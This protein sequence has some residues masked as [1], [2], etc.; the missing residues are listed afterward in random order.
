[1]VL[2]FRSQAS[3]GVIQAL[4]ERVLPAYEA[5]LNDQ[6]CSPGLFHRS[7]ATAR[8]MIAWLTINESEVAT[9][10]IRG[11]YRFLRHDCHCPADV[12]NQSAAPSPSHA[13][14]FLGYLLETGQAAV[15]ASIVAGGGLVEAFA[16]TLVAQ[17]YRERTVREVRSCCRHLVV[18]LYRSELALGAIEDRV[19]Q[20]FLDHRCD[21]EHPGF[22]GRS[23][24]FAGSRRTQAE[25]AK[26]ASF[27][28]DRDVVADWRD[29]LPKASGGAHT[30]AFLRWLRQHR[31]VRDTTLKAYRQSLQALL[32]LLGDAPGA[33]DAASVRAVILGRAQSGSRNTA[34]GS[35]LRSYLRFLAAQGLCRPGLVAAV[36][37]I[38]RRT[39][40]QLPRYV[41]QEDIEAL[42]ASCDT[43]TSIGLRD[44]AVLLLLARLALRPGEV[45][46]LRLDDIDWEQALVAVSGKSRRS[47]ALPLP[48][49]TGDTLKDYILRARPRTA[50]PTVFPRFR[51]PHGCL[52]SAAVSAIVRRAMQRAGIDGEGLPAAYVFRHSRATHLLRGG[53]APEAVGALLRHQSVKTTALYARVDAPMLLTVAQPWP[54]E[55]R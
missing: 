6:R 25:I 37:S 36:P 14:R 34:E 40:S 16:A 7:T 52:S 3:P 30:D 55:P 51:A 26:F 29:P 44:R 42:I 28:I 13:H 50:C 38:P 32:P 11:V 5:H 4:G 31:G 45:A 18:W 8:H 9:L 2:P 46:A 43:A 22:F 47:A 24:A 48:Q 53:A 23:S 39:A 27:L 20:R 35:A 21:C 54:E 15:P 19:L 49:E 33:Y 10:D 12:R 1:M 41:E 17:G